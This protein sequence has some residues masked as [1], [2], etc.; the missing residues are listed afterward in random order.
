VIFKI[1]ERVVNTEATT[2]IPKGM[3]GTIGEEDSCPWVTWDN[4]EVWCR[5]D[6]HLKLLDAN[7]N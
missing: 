6:K 7:K 4:G 5:E 1:G 3:T 2:F